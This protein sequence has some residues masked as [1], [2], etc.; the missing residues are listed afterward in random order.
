[1]IKIEIW[2]NQ[3]NILSKSNIRI[4]GIVAQ[5]NNLKNKIKKQH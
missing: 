4:N 5:P 2:T 1:M 3:G